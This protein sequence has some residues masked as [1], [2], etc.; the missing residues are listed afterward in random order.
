MPGRDGTGPLGEGPMTGK[1]FGYCNADNINTV[2]PY[3]GR[4]GYRRYYAC[5]RTGGLG[6]GRG[7]RDRYLVYNDPAYRTS[8][9]IGEKQLL[10]TELKELTLEI[11]RIKKKL[12]ILN[13][14]DEM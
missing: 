1:G 7:F 6:Y 4:G 8:S 12:D 11:N 2:F 9:D 14:N 5:R 13:K 3:F 10:E